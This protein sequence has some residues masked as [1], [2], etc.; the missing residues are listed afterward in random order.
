MAGAVGERDLEVE[1]RAVED[2]IGCAARVVEHADAPAG[3][4]VVAQAEDRGDG[5]LAHGSAEQEL[6]AT[7]GE[8][9]LGEPLTFERGQPVLASA[10]VSSPQAYHSGPVTARSTQN[11][12]SP[13]PKSSPPMSPASTG[14]APATGVA[15][16]T[17]LS[18]ATGVGGLVAAGVAGL[19]TLADS[20]GLADSSASGEES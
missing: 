13:P 17:R 8:P 19:C 12:K 16:P 7:L 4:R 3:C 9:D 6:G 1:D 20:A 15:R 2:D 11:P 10:M 5:A 14:V 18:P